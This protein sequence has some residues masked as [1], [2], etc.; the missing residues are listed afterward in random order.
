MMCQTEVSDTCLFYDESPLHFPSAQPACI[1][2]L[3]INLLYGTHTAGKRHRK[4]I[5]IKQADHDFKAQG[6]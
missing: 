3:S 4:K 2:E 5:Y 6:P 1:H